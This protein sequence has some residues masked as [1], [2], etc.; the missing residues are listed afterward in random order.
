MAFTAPVVVAFGSITGSFV[1]MQATVRS[2]IKYALLWNNTNQSLS[3][4]IA[5][6]V[7][8]LVLLAGEKWE[9]NDP[10]GDQYTFF[11]RHTGTAPTTGNATLTQ[12]VK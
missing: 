4:S 3:V 10:S 11:I 12:M 8:N 9:I 5:G 1:A 2:Q 7:E 6:T